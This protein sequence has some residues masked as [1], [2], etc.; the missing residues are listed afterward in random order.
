MSDDIVSVDVKNSGKPQKDKNSSMGKSKKTWL[1]VVGV[2]LLVAAI[3]SSVYFYTQYNDVKNNPSDAIAEKNT[4]ETDRVLTALKAVL[5][6]NETDSP[7]VARVED[8]EKLKSSNTEFYKDV[9]TGDYLIIFPKRAIIFRE[10]SNQVINV[11]PIINTSELKAQQ[12]AAA[13]EAAK[14]TPPATQKTTR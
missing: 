3:G 9:Q 8:P 10:S 14:S 5:L 4:E 7:T 12:D 2:V 1:V 6:I 11:A 13:A